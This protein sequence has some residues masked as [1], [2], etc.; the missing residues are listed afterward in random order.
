MK[1]L[2]GRVTFQLPGQP[3]FTLVE[4]AKDVFTMQPLPAD[5]YS[6]MV[7]RDAA[8]KVER[9]TVKQP[10]GEFGFRNTAYVG[11]SLGITV[12]DLH[13]KVVQAAGG[14][15]NIRKVTSRVSTFDIDLVHQGVQ[16]HGTTWIKAPNKQASETTFTALG[17]T[18][19]LGYDYFDGTKGEDISTISPAEAYTGKKLADIKLA[20]DLYGTLD[21]KTSYDRV[22]LSRT[23]KCGDE[24]CF[25]V[26]FTPKD[27][28]KFTEYY[29][30]KT[31]L[32]IKREGVQTASTM[33]IQIPYTIMFSDYR[34]VDGVKIPFKTM[35][36]TVTNGDVVT[37][38]RSVK[39]NVK[40]DDSVFGP[41]KVKM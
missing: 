21:W 25:A 20:S 35:S 38:V 9:V 28:T 16:A 40:V 10:E 22:D 32:L 24:E 31:F 18:I 23:A 29:S 7:K 41:K 19:A 12:D 4:K 27:G 15:T 14:E 1:E 36:S 34:D 33:A 13:N 30:T 11:T 37:T 2:D 3:A 26:A 39:H 5:S 8:G 17:K 6:L